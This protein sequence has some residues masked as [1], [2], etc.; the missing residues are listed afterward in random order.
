MRLLAPA[1]VRTLAAAVALGTA[2]L[3]LGALPAPAAAAASCAPPPVGHRGEPSVAPENTLA[4]FR[5]AL[6]HGARTIELDVRFTSSDV[7]VVLHDPTV[8][9]TTDGTG[10]V[11]AM[12][13]TQLRAYDAGSWFGPSYAGEKV[14][15]L[16][17]VLKLAK[18]HGARAV[19]DLKVTPTSRETYKFLDRINRLGMQGSVLVESRKTTAIAKVRSAAPRLRTALVDSTTVRRAA[20]VRQYGQSYTVHTDLGTPERVSAWDGAG[21]DVYA[22]FYPSSTD[23]PD[24]WQRYAGSVLTGTMTDRTSDYLAWAAAGCP[25]G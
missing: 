18:A 21:I 16:Y 25:S 23:T 10:A 14:P 24:Q 6:A 20:E 9:R 13:F 8:D 19:I 12:T 7:P 2:L 1:C 11:T 4:S 3:G 17:E 15:T 22:Y 5:A